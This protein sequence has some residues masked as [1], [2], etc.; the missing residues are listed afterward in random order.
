MPLSCPGTW[1]GAHENNRS[2]SRRA[3]Y[4]AACCGRGPR[5]PDQ[6]PR[7]PQRPKERRLSL[8]RRQE[9]SSA[10]SET[11][12]QRR[13]I[14][15]LLGCTSRGSGTGAT[16]RTRIRQTLRPGQ[17][18]CRMRVATLLAVY[19]LLSGCAEGE[20]RDQAAAA[21]EIA[22]VANERAE[23]AEMAVEDLERRVQDIE[24]SIDQ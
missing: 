15:E 20:A 17:R 6:R 7:L 21:E 22:A 16:R 19:L 13:C 24:A 2:R 1:G 23:R 18:R 4:G 12:K 3:A 11:A 8:P 5:R 10:S 9:V 14:S